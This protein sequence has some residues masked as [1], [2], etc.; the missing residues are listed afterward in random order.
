[1]LHFKLEHSGGKKIRRQVSKSKAEKNQQKPNQIENVHK[2]NHVNILLLFKYCRN[3]KKKK[4][5]KKN[6]FHYYYSTSNEMTINNNILVR[7]TKK[8][9]LIFLF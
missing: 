9:E 1:M 6:T 8:M 3:C 4:K 2:Q 7:N 5:L